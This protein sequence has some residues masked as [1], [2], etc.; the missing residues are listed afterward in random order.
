MN[1]TITPTT[2]LD[3]LDAPIESEKWR[4]LHFS[5]CGKTFFGTPT[6]KSAE[7][8]RSIIE[9]AYSD[10][11]NGIGQYDGLGSADIKILYKDYSHTIQI[12]VKS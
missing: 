12:P 5:K 8:A 9:L 10:W 4:N 7:E 3:Y 1:P 2:N 6:Y 11:K